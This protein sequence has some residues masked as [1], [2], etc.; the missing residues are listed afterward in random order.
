VAI[1]ELIQNAHDGS[2]RRTVEQKEAFY[3]PRIHI[4]VDALAR[5]LTI[6][7][8]GSAWLPTK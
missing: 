4:R 1:R 8:N 5:T 7:D 3:R 6:Q 2:V